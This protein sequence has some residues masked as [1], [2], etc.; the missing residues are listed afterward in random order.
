MGAFVPKRGKC[1]VLAIPV[2]LNHP[3]SILRKRL[4]NQMEK[5][6]SKLIK[7][8]KPI[9]GKLVQNAMFVVF[10]NIGIQGRRLMIGTRWK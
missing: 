10:L 8:E 9:I 2:I 5:P 6:T 1:S 3:R 4:K 7:Y